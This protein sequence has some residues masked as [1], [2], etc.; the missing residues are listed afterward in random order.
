MMEVYFLLKIMYWCQPNVLISENI[1]QTLC[2]FPMYNYFYLLANC[3]GNTSWS[4]LLLNLCVPRD[5]YLRAT[6]VLAW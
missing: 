3:I 2:V 4:D 5:N 6:L 1:S